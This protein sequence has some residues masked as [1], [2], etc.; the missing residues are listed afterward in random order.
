MTNTEA[1]KASAK[2][3]VTTQNA[4]API[5]GQFG[6]TLAAKLDIAGD[7]ADTIGLLLND[8]HT[9]WEMAQTDTNVAH[10]P[11]NAER[12]GNR[13]DIDLK[14]LISAVSHYCVGNLTTP[15]PIAAPPLLCYTS[16]G[17]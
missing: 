13:I 17:S 4:S 2:A 6:N 14:S 7:I 8:D 9:V 11:A 10:N 3:A 12:R 5:N 16:R 1:V 15:N